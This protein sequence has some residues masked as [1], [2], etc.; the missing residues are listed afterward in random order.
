M[1]IDSI[2]R[3]FKEKHEL[4]KHEKRMLDALSGT[5]DHEEHLKAMIIKQV[6]AIE[7]GLCSEN[8]RLGFGLLRIEAMLDYLKEYLS[9][10]GDPNLDEC[11]MA[12]G[13]LR[14]YFELHDMVKWK[15]EPY[16]VIREKAARVLSEVS[17]EDGF[18]G[19]IVIRPLDQALDDDALEEI[20]RSRH[21]IRSFSAEQVDAEKLKKALELAM[22]APSACNRQPTRV[23]ILH[24]DDFDLIK[25]WTGGVKTFIDQVDK[26]LIITS[27]MSAFEKDEYYQ[28]TVSAG[29]FV[30]YLTLTLHAEGIGNCVLQRTL[31]G[32]YAWNE[33]RH[34]IGIP[35]NEQSICAIA[36]GVPKAEVKVPVSKRLNY[37]RIVK[38]INRQSS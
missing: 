29:I 23:Y 1:G 28:Y 3:Y 26:L 35:Q 4:A 10:G 17:Q 22:S 14:Q 13:A 2:K 34:Q 19:S 7:K 12:K 38:N 32:N 16:L 21:S 18:G 37:D 30:G 8:L 9:G 33:I 36:I 11:R 15:E 25:N 20:I 6:H 27:Q 5:I 24:H 31:I